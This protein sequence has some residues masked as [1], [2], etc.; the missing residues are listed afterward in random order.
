MVVMVLA[1]AHFLFRFDQS[2][3]LT[4]QKTATTI[5]AMAAGLHAGMEMSSADSLLRSSD[6]FSGSR[7]CA[8]IF[9]VYTF[10]DGSGER[11]YQ[12]IWLERDS[13]PN[14]DKVRRAGI[15]TS[16]EVCQ[17]PRSTMVRSGRGS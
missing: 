8:G 7:S 15:S 11:R 17:G 5:N 4:G 2:L 6:I 16:E 14:Q 12:E 1:V 3:R 9:T 13:Y 10:A